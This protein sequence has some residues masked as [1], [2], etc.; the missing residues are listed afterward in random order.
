METGRERRRLV[1]VV[2]TSPTRGRLTFEEVFRDILAFMA[3]NP[4]DEYRLIVGTDS[5]IRQEACFVTAIVVHRVGKGGRYYYAKEWENV[6]RSLKKRIFHE[7]ARSLALAGRLNDELGAAG[8]TGIDLE[9]HLDIGGR[10]DTKDVIRDVTG[11]VTGTGFAA[12]IKPDAYGA[13]T[14]AD[15]HT[16]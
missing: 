11:M 14:V 7:A 10:G 13:S 8:V 16:K 5:Q 6:G 15:R 9:I 2:F 1:S 12:F 4:E 3:E